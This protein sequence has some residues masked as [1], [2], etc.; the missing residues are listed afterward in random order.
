[1]VSSAFL[2]GIVLLLVITAKAMGS[3]DWVVAYPAS[4]YT[5]ESDPVL[6][7]TTLTADVLRKRSASEPSTPATGSVSA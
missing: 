1:M 5:C 3:P 4:E 6:A 2:V 7:R